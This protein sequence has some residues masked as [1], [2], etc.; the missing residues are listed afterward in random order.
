MRISG[1]YID[2]FGHFRDVNLSGLGSG[3]TV[4]HGPNEA[5]KTTLLAF[6]RYIMFGFP[7]ARSSM[8]AFTPQRGGQHGGRLF[9][10]A[11]DTPYTLSRFNGANGGEATVTAGD[12][13]RVSLSDLIG[14][15]DRTVF[16]SVFAFGI[17]ELHEFSTLQA[18]AVRERIFS[19]GILGTGQSAQEILRELERRQKE[20]FAPRT[21]D[22]LIPKLRGELSALRAK[23]RMAADASRGYG[24][25]LGEEERLTKS[26]ESLAQGIVESERRA[27]DLETLLAV[28]QDW[29]DA[30]EIEEKLACLPGLDKVPVDA[31]SRLTRL[32]SAVSTEEKRLREIQGVRGE[33]VASIARL[34]SDD[35]VAWEIETEVDAARDVLALARDWEQ[36]RAVSASRVIEQARKVEAQIVRLG[37]DWSVDRVVSFDRSIARMEEARRLDGAIEVSQ[38]EVDKREQEVR[39]HEDA[40]DAYQREC[41]AAERH[42]LDLPE[43][44]TGDLDGRGTRIAAVARLLTE[45]ER[46]QGSLETA[47]ANAEEAQRAA[48][49]SSQ[50]DSGERLSSL[51]WMLVAA[52]LALAA[53]G[54]WSAFA[55]ERSSLVTLVVG[56]LIA[57]VGFAMVRPRPSENQGVGERAKRARVVSD[58][59]KRALD[60]IIS[61]LVKTSRELGLERPPSLEELERLRQDLADDRRVLVER[62]R[63][64]QE[65]ER[66]KQTLASSAELLQKA[67][68]AAREA[69]E[70]LAESERKWS[71]WK[72]I[73]A[74]PQSLSHDGVVDFIDVVREAQEA[75]SAR[76]AAS[77]D[78]QMLDQKIGS[79]LQRASAIAARTENAL[80]ADVA[81][82]ASIL[83]KV[84]VRCDAAQRQ[85]ADKQ[86]LQRELER[87][88]IALESADRALAEARADLS[89]FLTES[90]AESAEQLEEMLRL[91]SMQNALTSQHAAHDRAVALRLGAGSRSKALRTE[92]ESANPD[93]WEREMEMLRE[94]STS[95]RDDRDVALRA[96]QDASNNRRALEQAAD[97]PSI[98]LEIA[99]CES[100]LAT[101]TYQWRVLSAARE[102]VTRTLTRF[103]RERQPAVIA[104]AAEL[105]AAV[106]NGTYP[107][108]RQGDGEILVIDDVAGERDS[109]LLSRG[110][111]E[112]LYLCVRLGLCHELAQRRTTLPL[113][114]DDVLVNFDGERAAAVGRLLIDVAQE[115]QVLLFTCHQHIRDMLATLDD[116]VKVIELPRY[117]GNERPASV[118][119]K[120]SRREPR[121]ADAANSPAIRA[122]DGELSEAAQAILRVLGESNQAMGKKGILDQSHVNEAEWGRAI[123]ELL[124][125]DLVTS[126]GQKRGTIY[127]LAGM[128]G[129]ADKEETADDTLE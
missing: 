51:R 71:E 88:D 78:V 118:V 37:L 120:K 56:L 43:V 119:V 30:R 116:S 35:V 16:E 19:G 34:A 96:L 86:N 103:E 24:R 50:G 45:R 127:R 73:A 66:L 81:T 87:N 75:I 33:T 91:V 72:R 9:L 62:K 55:G 53:F 49:A 48:D 1:W 67:S 83:A 112:Q 6:V 68:D 11:H 41:E 39:R 28:W 89:N 102:L 111:R 69:T 101:A 25:V 70:R 84:R 63:V 22:A 4:V 20:L 40:H 54:A 26:T 2:G 125:G 61:E 15:A 79:F 46:V 104:R 114:M 5:G 52:G 93:G 106:T 129:D 123:G 97:V 36:Q 65:F 38:R 13:R 107:R 126:S 105:F 80:P 108:L 7:H 85:I 98:E 110:T 109:S 90:S 59:M 10:D 77:A 17:D 57:V 95:L 32:T 18:D 74:V 60:G 128:A 44:S 113:V 42:L 31:A 64:Q 21:R 27:T 121:V 23:L 99:Q 100:Q 124:D 122:K 58:D 94:K 12:G 82:A 29:Y 117:A 47:Q 3:L 8:P 92:L 76:D 14:V 115:Q